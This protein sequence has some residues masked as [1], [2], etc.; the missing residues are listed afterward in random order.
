MN[1]INLEIQ[2]PNP[3]AYLIQKFIIKDRR[4]PVFHQ[5][6]CF[7]IYE[8][9][10]KFRDNFNQLKNCIDNVLVMNSRKGH[11]RK[12]KNFKANFIDYFSSVSAGGIT[13]C[14]KE[15]RDRGHNSIDI[16]D[17]VATFE[18]FIEEIK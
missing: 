10:L 15:L 3:G 4:K 7:Y 13:L 16:E 9:L 6:D 2:I 5:K 14:Y 17:I 18:L 12:V 1:D 11:Y 8:L